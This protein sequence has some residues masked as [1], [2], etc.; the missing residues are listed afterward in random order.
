MF[1]VGIYVPP[2][3]QPTL[4]YLILERIAPYCPTNLL[5][6]GDFN[7]VLSPDLDRPHPSKSFAGELSRWALSADLREAWSWKHSTTRS[8]L[9]VR[10]LVQDLLQN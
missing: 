1:F 8:Y 7:A 6:L 9:C 5:F 10:Y 2:P 4:L 3:F